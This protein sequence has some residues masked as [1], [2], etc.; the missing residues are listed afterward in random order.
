MAR[1]FLIKASGSDGL[2]LG[3]EVAS[4]NEALTA[5]FRASGTYAVVTEWKADVDV[6][7]GAPVIKKE[8]IRHEKK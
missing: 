3:Q 5:S 2:H 7:S 8:A 6:S 4:E 1:Y